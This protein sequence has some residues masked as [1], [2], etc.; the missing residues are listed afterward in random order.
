MTDPILE[1]SKRLEEVRNRLG[2]TTLRDFWRVLTAD[3]AC[4]VSY[5]AVRNYHLNRE[6]PAQYLAQVARVFGARLEWLV[7]GEGERFRAESEIRGALAAASP[8]SSS[9]FQSGL[10]AALREEFPELDALPQL[11][12]NAFF[13]TLIRFAGAAAE[14]RLS[15]HDLARL[16]GDIGRLLLHPQDAW[17]FFPDLSDRRFTDYALA[18]LH[19][20]MIAVPEQGAGELLAE[21]FVEREKNQGRLPG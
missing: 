9:R 17:G 15:T 4:Q 18:L 1:S 16:G 8:V 5:E 11:V 3:G 2:Y 6:A 13:E 20:V 19:A 12:V 10:H 14:A 21:R 7:T